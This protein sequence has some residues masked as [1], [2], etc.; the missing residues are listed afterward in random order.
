MNRSAA[1]RACCVLKG[2]GRLKGFT[3]VEL[4]VS[5][6][7]IAVLA[8]LLATAVAKAKTKAYAISCISN[9]RQLTLGALLYATDQDD[10]LPYNLGSS[11]TKRGTAPRADYNWVN[12]ILNW[13]VLNSD[14]TNVAFV[15]KGRFSQYISRAAPIYRCPADRA[16]SEDQKQAGW[17]GRVRSY[18]MNAMVGDAGENSRW[19]T[20][21]FNP[22]Y[23]QFKRTTE[24]AQPTRIFIFVDEHPDSINDGYFLNRVDELE[25]LDLPASYHNNAATLSFADGHVEMHRWI[26]PATRPPPKPYAAGLPIT[27]DA[28]QRADYDWLVYRTTV[29]Y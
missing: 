22:E 21:I 24:I 5:I 8:G 29:W 20:N 11:A 23:K 1:G 28:D 13:D 6:A 10:R 12:N 9:V 14:N 4:L 3:L 18:S 7:I 15:T 27:I 17:N 26:Y 19:G 25:W 2:I 16:L